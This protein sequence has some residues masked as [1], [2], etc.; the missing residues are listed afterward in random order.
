M[1]EN[2]IVIGQN[3]V[4]PTEANLKAG[5]L[6]SAWLNF[7]CASNTRNPNTAD[8]HAPIVSLEPQFRVGKTYYMW[9]KT[10]MVHHV[11]GFDYANHFVKKPLSWLSETHHVDTTPAYEDEK[12][13]LVAKVET[14]VTNGSHYMRRLH[15]NATHCLVWMTDA[16]YS[17]LS[18]EIKYDAKNMPTNVVAENVYFD[19]V[20]EKGE[21]YI[22]PQKDDL[23]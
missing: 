11:S 10:G 19:A 16:N 15:K 22:P 13:K 7:V 2:V 4:K 14:P 5:S 6:L 23:I 1:F 12:G 20:A 8:Y 18:K 3:R 9:L 21:F 17:E